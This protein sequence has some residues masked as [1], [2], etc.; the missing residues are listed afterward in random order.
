MG[1]ERRRRSAEQG[2]DG[3]GPGSLLV[4][5]IGV[6]RIGGEGRVD[7][8]MPE[9]QHHRAGAAGRQAADGQRSR[10]RRGVELVPG[11]GGHV[12][13]QVGLGVAE[14]RVDALGVD[15]VV[16]GGIGHD[17]EGGQTDLEG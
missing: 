14:L 4:L 16:P 9:G 1:V 15:G 13:D 2:V 17:E 11:E 3:L 10:R 7:G 8:R 12:L 5:G 6:P